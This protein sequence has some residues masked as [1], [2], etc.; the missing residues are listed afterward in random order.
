MEACKAAKKSFHLR[1]KSTS[2]NS[3]SKASED[4]RGRKASDHSNNYSNKNNKVKTAAKGKQKGKAHALYDYTYDSDD[5]VVEKP[6][7]R[8]LVDKRAGIIDLD[9]FVKET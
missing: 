3:N 7:A 8:A 6:I 1:Q 2:V 5:S 9:D 4:S